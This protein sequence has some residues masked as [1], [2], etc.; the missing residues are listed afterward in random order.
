VKDS[1]G[2]R[3]A[4]R[5]VLR[6]IAG[7]ILVFCALL[8]VD[9]FAY[10]YG[11]SLPTPSGNQGENGLWLRYKWYFGEKTEAERATLPAHLRKQQIRY[12]YF[13]VRFIERGGKL[14]FRYPESAKILTDRLKQ[15]APEIRRIAWIYVGNSRGEG[16]VN[17]GNPDVRRKMIEEAVW[18]IEVCGFDG[19]QWDYEICAQGDKGL[20]ALLRESRAALPPGT[21]LG[22]AT[23]LYAPAPFSSLG[24]GWNAA[25]YA[26]IASLCDQIAVMGYDSG[27]Y[28]P[29]AYAALIRSQV[30]GVTRAA[31]KANPSCRILIGV[32][33]YW[34]GGPSHHPYAENLAVAL[35]GVREGFAALSAEER[36]SFAG[37]APFADYTT[38]ENEWAIWQQQWLDKNTR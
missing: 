27:I 9:Y 38:D 31:R 4:K 13:H 12:A 1:L 35:R 15:D 23:P 21:L 33:T 6:R 19:I 10:P 29:R 16:N 36:A 11:A 30:I 17:L 5:R 25:Y 22:V 8:I 24:Y 18:L 7:A 34:K 14:H 20:T 32:P 3:V 37:V 28:L 2:K 26:E